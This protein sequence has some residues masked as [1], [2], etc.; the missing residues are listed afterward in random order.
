MPR[1]RLRRDPRHGGDGCFDAHVQP[2]SSR[3]RTGATCPGTPLSSCSPRS[4]NVQS[5]AGQQVLHGARHDDVAAR[6]RVAATR[7]PMCTASPPI[8]SPRTSTSPVCTP[9][10]IA[11]PIG[12]S[13]S[14]I[15]SRAAD[16]P[17]RVRRTW[18]G[19]RRRRCRSRVR[20]SGR[21]RWR[22]IAS[23]CVE[24]RAPAGVTEL[25]GPRGGAD[26]VGEEDRREPSVGI[27]RGCERR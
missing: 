9:A 19:T 7:A 20:R 25:G 27:G 24:Q 18:R 5:R 21:A 22:T 15:A 3:R 26:D 14:R 1:H 13:A 16:G 11:T 4:T 8:R 10:R 12:A 6:R 2:L 23:C 17:R